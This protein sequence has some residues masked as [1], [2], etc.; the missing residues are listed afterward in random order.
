MNGLHS[1]LVFSGSIC[2]SSP[3]ISLIG[4]NAGLPAYNWLGMVDFPPSNSLETDMGALPRKRLR[5]S[6]SPRL[7]RK[8]KLDQSHSKKERGL[9]VLAIEKTFH[10]LLASCRKFIGKRGSQAI[11]WWVAVDHNAVGFLE[12]LSQGCSYK[13]DCYLALQNLRYGLA[14]G[15]IEIHFS[16]NNGRQF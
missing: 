9:H 3:L 7:Y 6:T 4:S 14:T 15:L 1:P 8:K 5:I 13:L 12:T 11:I 2:T 16:C 10:Q